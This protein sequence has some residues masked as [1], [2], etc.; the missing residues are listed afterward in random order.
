M[1]AMWGLAHALEV[2]SRRMLRV[3]GVTGP[4]RL[5][6][7]VIGQFPDISSGDIA[8]TMGL[9]P[10]TL[11]GVLARL[12]GQ[13]LVERLPDPTDGRRVRYRLT[14]AGRK[15]DRERRGT[16]EAAVRRALGRAGETTVEH[17]VRMIGVLV[18]E[19]DREA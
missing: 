9:H 17:T 13:K 10:S 3:L 4:Q 14:R 18:A 2:T 15:I 5:V 12:V 16:V 7:R 1:Q 6:I 8:A 11:T 19:L